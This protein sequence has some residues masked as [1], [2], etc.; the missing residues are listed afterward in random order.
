MQLR[1]WWYFGGSLSADVPTN[2]LVVPWWVPYCGCALQAASA[3]GSLGAYTLMECS[4]LMTV[5]CRE[6]FL[7]NKSMCQLHAA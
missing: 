3:E 5:H 6:N 4:S 7:V 2:S 1:A